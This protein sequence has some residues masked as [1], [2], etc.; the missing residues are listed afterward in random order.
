MST[1]WCIAF[2]P[3][4]SQGAHLLQGNILEMAKENYI[5]D[6]PST[7]ITYHVERSSFAEPHSPTAS[8]TEACSAVPCLRDQIPLTAAGKIKQCPSPSPSPPQMEI[9]LNRSSILVYAVLQAMKGEI[10]Q[11]KKQESLDHSGWKRSLRYPGPIPTHPTFPTDHIPPCH[12]STVLEHLHGWE[13][14]H[15]LDSCAP[16]SSKN[17]HVMEVGEVD[18]SVLRRS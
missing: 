4:G 7:W 9:P 11:K 10:V 16:A 14:S 13:L 2:G 5:F 18:I 8:G 12:I 15:P 1:P 6:L 3:R 17:I